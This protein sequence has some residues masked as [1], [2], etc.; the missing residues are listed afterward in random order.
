MKEDELV[1][2]MR[3][4][5][6]QLAKHAEVINTLNKNQQALVKK[7]EGFEKTEEVNKRVEEIIK[8]TQ[9]STAAAEAT[10]APAAPAAPA[11][12]ATPPAAPPATPA[13]PADPPAAPPAT[14]PAAPAKKE[15]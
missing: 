10:P 3:K 13:T 12:P 7:I 4:A 1:K 11:T 9:A 14:P 5:N 2:Y 15:E 6:D 8:Q